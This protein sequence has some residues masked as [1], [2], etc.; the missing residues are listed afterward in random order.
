M[1]NLIPWRGEIDRLR[2]EMDRLYDRFFDW[3]PFHRFAEEGEWSPS[4]D[5]SE[6]SKEVVVTAE[7]PGLEAKDIDVSLDG[8]VL[9]LRGERKKESE[10]KDANFHRVE[11]T[12]GSFSRSIRLPTE[13]DHEKIKATY[14]Q[15][16]LKIILT[17]TAKESGKKIEIKA[18]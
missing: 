14:K 8:S 3:R 10:E 11:R 16:V 6:T 12:Y 15:G 4:V 17:K 9:R 1:S 5:V 7:I 13:V 2:N 18:T